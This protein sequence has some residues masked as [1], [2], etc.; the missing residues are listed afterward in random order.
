MKLCL[1][2]REVVIRA[3]R[4][5]KYKIIGEKEGKSDSVLNTLGGTHAFNMGPETEFQKSQICSQ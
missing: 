1:P 3:Q 5:A 2:R 4:D